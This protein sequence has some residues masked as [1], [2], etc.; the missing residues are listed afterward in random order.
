MHEMSLAEGIRSIVDDAVS[1][2]QLGRVRSV[3]VEIGE[4]SAV[5]VDALAFCFEAVMKGG[6]AEG[7]RMEVV[8]VPG[9]GWCMQ[10]A[11]T[12]VV[13]RLYDPCPQ[14]GSYQVQPTGGTEMR[15]R[16]LEVD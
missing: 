15:V 12:V 1:S 3:V 9:S 5:E 10:C 2:Q 16:E 13:S 7:A 8:R 6:P 4:L 14:C 11:Q